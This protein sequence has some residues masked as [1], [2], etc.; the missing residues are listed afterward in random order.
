MLSERWAQHMNVMTEPADT[1]RLT[2]DELRARAAQI[3]IEQII[4][5]IDAGHRMA[6]MAVTEDDKE[7]LRRVD[8]GDT[9][10]EE[11]RDRLL[12]EISARHLPISDDDRRA[13]IPDTQ[14]SGTKPCGIQSPW[15]VVRSESSSPS[16]EVRFSL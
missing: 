14:G 13:G 11:E 3:D 5:N 7:S 9:T 10:I 6:G 12:A 8:R 2:D 16:G 15:S 4:A 1:P